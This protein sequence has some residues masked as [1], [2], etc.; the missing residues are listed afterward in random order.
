[1]LHCIDDDGGRDNA[2][3]DGEKEDGYVYVTHLRTREHRCG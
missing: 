2:E 1:L 3:D